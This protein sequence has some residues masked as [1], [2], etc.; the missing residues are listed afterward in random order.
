[1][2]KTHGAPL[3]IGTEVEMLAFTTVREGTWFLTDEPVLYWFNGA[4]W[5]DVSQ[6][7][8][9]IAHS[10][11]SGLTTSGHPASIISVDT[12]SFT[13]VFDVADDT[14]QEALEAIDN[15]G[16]MPNPMTAEGDMIYL[17]PNTVV[18]NPTPYILELIHN[19]TSEVIIAD[20]DLTVDVGTSITVTW[21]IWVSGIAYGVYKDYTLRVRKESLTGTVLGSKSARFGT[22]SSAGHEQQW[23]S[24][25]LDNAPTDGRYVVT[26]Q[27]NGGWPLYSDTRE[28]TLSSVLSSPTRLPIGSTGEVLKVVGGYPDWEPMLTY[29]LVLGDSTNNTT[30]ETDG[31]IKFNGSATVFDDI[32]CSISSA[33]V[34]GAALLA[35]PNGFYAYR[36]NTNQ[37]VEFDAQEVSHAYKEGSSIEF[38]IHWVT[39]VSDASDRYVKW[40]IE[41]SYTTGPAIAA[42]FPIYSDT[43]TISAETTVPANTDD[44]SEITTSI[45]TLLDANMK[46]GGRILAK[47]TRIA[48][49]S[50]A[51]SSGPFLTQ[52]GIHVEK[53]TLGS[54]SIGAK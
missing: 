45:G 14:V 48:A 27:L 19:S 8:E 30:I 3:Y 54:R 11:L 33:R 25:Y 12:S 22:D 18:S 51:P 5:V 7:A 44:M 43:V 38:H 21:N 1:M 10:A 34:T 37:S 32:A 35:M 15:I 52:F 26:A 24:S 39:G 28:F 31:T 23:T 17:G 2:V 13:K 36:F 41:Y 47:V 46:M 6:S 53:D 4:S 40:Q 50:T 20:M 49:S 29:P 16:I 42:P 9:A